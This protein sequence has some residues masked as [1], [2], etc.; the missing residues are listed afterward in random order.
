MITY[1]ELSTNNLNKSKKKLKLI[2][3]SSSDNYYYFVIIINYSISLN[4]YY[5]PTITNHMYSTHK[6][7]STQSY[8]KLVVKTLI[9]NINK[10]NTIFFFLNKIK[11]M[12]IV[13]NLI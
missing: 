9:F 2:T 10:I 12:L 3:T 1:Y 13:S 6:N 11:R 4:L 7:L 5:I 8:Y